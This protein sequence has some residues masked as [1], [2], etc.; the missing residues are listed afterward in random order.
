MR[1]TTTS[2]SGEPTP[3]S[4]RD[5]DLLVAVWVQ[6]RARRAAIAGV[7]DGRLRLQVTSPAHENRANDD[8]RRLLSKALGVAPSTVTVASGGKSRRKVLRVADLAPDEARRRLDLR[9]E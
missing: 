3:L 5:G 2:S 7:A 6:P 1:S 9:K 8:A 4:A